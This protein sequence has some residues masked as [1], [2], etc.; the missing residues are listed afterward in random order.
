ETKLGKLEK[1]FKDDDI[2]ANVLARVRGNAQIVEVTI[3][4]DKFILRSEEENDDLYAA[5]DLV[6]DKL[7]RQIRKNKTRLNRNIKDSVKEFNFD[8]DIRDEEEAKEKVVKRK[9]IEM[10]PMDE[11]EAI[12][13]MELLGHSFFVY[14][15]MDTKNI[16]VLYKR[17][18]GDYGL[19]E[20]K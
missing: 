7:E 18:D 11:E 5:I 6:T 15:D 17:K 8:F 2:T 3:P 10:K 16:C 19:I 13:E 20:T 9:N 1:Y 4:T 12:L 14:K